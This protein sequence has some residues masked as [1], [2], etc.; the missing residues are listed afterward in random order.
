MS[1]PLPAYLATAFS[2]RF[3]D[4]GVA[5]ALA[6]LALERTG[7]PAQGALALTAWMAP[8]ALAAPFV[9]ALAERAR[10]PRAFHVLA[11]SL[12]AVSLAAL[13]AVLGRAPLAAPLGCAALGGACGPVVTGGLSG[14]LARLLPDP[15]V[16]T[17]AYALDA[18]TYNAASVLAPAA[19][20]VTAG[21]LSATPATALLAGAATAAAVLALRIPVPPANRD[22]ASEPTADRRPTPPEEPGSR[23]GRPANPPA[24]RKSRPAATVAAGLAALWRVPELRAITAATVVSFLGI[25]GLAVTAVLLTAAFGHPGAEGVPVTAFAVGGLLG[26]LGTARLRRRPHAQHLAACALFGTGAALAVAALVPWF[27]AAVAAFAAA[28]LCDGPLMAATLRLRADHA[29]ASARTQVFTLGAGLKVSAA[30]AGAALAGTL[31]FGPVPHLLA[32]AALQLTAALL[33]PLLCPHPRDP[34]PETPS[35]AAP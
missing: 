29:P 4:E 11:F 33:L 25:G 26:A 9:G 8:H 28:G 2:A 14:L 27:P 10:S 21:A 32:I 13:T 22:T 18:A 34:A 20:S 1:R 17:R 19:V 6:L 12:F 5:L 7:S 3:A 35:A 24:P 30:A 15:R 23:T 16:R 31:P